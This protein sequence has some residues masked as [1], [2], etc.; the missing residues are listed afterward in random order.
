MMRLTSTRHGGQAVFA[1]SGEL[2]HHE[3]RGLMAEI[4]ERIEIMAPRDV[5]LDLGELRFMDSSG[6]A[7]LLKLYKRLNATGGRLYVTNV[8]TQPMRVLDASG[9]DRMIRIEPMSPARVQ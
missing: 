7:I 1:L 2:D 9:I 5:V 8:Q 4:E 3:A 6:I